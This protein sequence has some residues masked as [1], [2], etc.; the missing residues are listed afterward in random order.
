MTTAVSWSFRQRFS[1]RPSTLLLAYLAAFAAAGAVKPWL[2]GLLESGVSWAQQTL[3]PGALLV[4][5]PAAIFALAFFVGSLLKRNPQ[6]Q[7][8]LEVL[9]SLGLLVLTP[10]Y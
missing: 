5:F 9:V 7:F 8:L 3:G 10:I 6:L 4:L 1:W 2:P